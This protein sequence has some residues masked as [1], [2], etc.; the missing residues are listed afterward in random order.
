MAVSGNAGCAPDRPG[1]TA[2]QPYGLLERVRAAQAPN[3]FNT[4]ATV[5]AMI[6]LGV[7]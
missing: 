7:S 6:W 4:S 3:S 1:T 2:P 5:T